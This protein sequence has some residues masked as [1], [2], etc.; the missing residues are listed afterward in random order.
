MKLEESI[1]FLIRTR[2]RIGVGGVVA[3]CKAGIFFF[4]L[5]LNLELASNVMP[6]FVGLNKNLFTNVHNRFVYGR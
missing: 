3:S 1:C 6:R 4:F 5:L 2:E